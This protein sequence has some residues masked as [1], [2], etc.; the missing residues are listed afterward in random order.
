M[1]Y[2]PAAPLRA[3]TQGQRVGSQ[4]TSLWLF[5]VAREDAFETTTVRKRGALRTLL[6]ILTF[7]ITLGKGILV[8]LSNHAQLVNVLGRFRIPTAADA[9]CRNLDRVGRLG[10]R[11]AGDCRG[12]A[13]VPAMESPAFL[14]GGCA[15]RAGDPR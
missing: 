1:R 15:A 8:V 6:R 11:A 9:T 3:T 10:T 4:E 14:V 7:V 13:S 2:P 5:A 12:H